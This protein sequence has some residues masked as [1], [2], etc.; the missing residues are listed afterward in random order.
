[1][2][3]GVLY[4]RFSYFFIS[5]CAVVCDIITKKWIMQRIFRQRPAVHN[6]ILIFEQNSR[7]TLIRHKACHKQIII[8][9]RQII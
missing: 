3:L 8:R 9:H 7:I 1:M 2:G 6:E 5:F 4:G